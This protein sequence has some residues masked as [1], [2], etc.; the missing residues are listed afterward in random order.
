MTQN[1][2]RRHPL[3]EVVGKRRDSE[4]RVMDVIRSFSPYALAIQD[5]V[6]RYSDLLR[7]AMLS[8]M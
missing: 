2:R 5:V 4:D 3:V 6:M 8:E 1:E 7:H